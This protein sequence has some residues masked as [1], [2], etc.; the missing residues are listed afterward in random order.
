MPWRLDF[1][2]QMRA[3]EVT[4]IANEIMLFALTVDWVVLAFE[5]NLEARL[6]CPNESQEIP[7]CVQGVPDLLI[8]LIW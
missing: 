1:P 2:L 4:E 3:E 5:K 7:I 8:L 6:V